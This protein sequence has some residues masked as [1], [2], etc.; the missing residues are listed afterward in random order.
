MAY[1]QHCCFNGPA[2]THDDACFNI[3]FAVLVD[4]FPGHDKPDTY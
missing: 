3:Q 4:P 2:E 1:Y